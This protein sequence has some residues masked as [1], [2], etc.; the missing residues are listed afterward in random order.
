MKENVICVGAGK[1]GTTWLYGLLR[2]HNECC[3]SNVKETMYFEHYFDRGAA[4]YEKHFNIEDS[5]KIASEVSNTYIFAPDVAQRIEDYNPSTKIVVTVR[6]PIERALSH[7]LFLVRSGMELP[8]FQNAIRDP[9]HNHLLSRGLYFKHMQPYLACFPVDQIQ[10][11][12]FEDLVA[13]AEAY[14]HQVL[15]FIGVDSTVPE[16][17]EDRY[18]LGASKPRSPRIARLLKKGANMARDLDMGPL[19]QKVKGSVVQRLAYRPLPREER[20]Q[21]TPALRAEL[22]EYY[23]ADVEALSCWMQRDLARLWFGG[24]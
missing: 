20:P 6:N 10:V 7:Y 8:P 19:V 23:R 1:C 17:D 5:H 14:A 11:L 22:A 13:D 15:D 21:I 16:F 24:K 18:R 12:V 9:E 3:A 4:W 2:A